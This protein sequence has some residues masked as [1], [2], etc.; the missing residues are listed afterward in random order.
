LAI[1]FLSIEKE[2]KSKQFS[3]SQLSIFISQLLK[4]NGSTLVLAAVAGTR[5]LVGILVKRN[6][7]Q[8]I[9]WVVT[10]RS[11]SAASGAL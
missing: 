8:T 4:T 11:Y 10:M 5:F 3:I 6:L 2:L 7:A 9:S 1:V